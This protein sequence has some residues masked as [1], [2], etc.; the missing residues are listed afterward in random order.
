MKDEKILSA[1]ELERVSGGKKEETN[2]IL[3]GIC[4]N[5]KYR[6]LSPEYLE[7][8]QKCPKCGSKSVYFF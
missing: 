8:G 3:S 2:T 7:S 5:C 1:E 6:F 4:K